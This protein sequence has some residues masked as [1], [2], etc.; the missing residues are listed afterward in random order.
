M[1]SLKKHTGFAPAINRC[2]SI[3]CFVRDL[4]FPPRPT[5]VEL[6]AAECSDVLACD[7]SGTVYLSFPLMLSSCLGDLQA[8][9]STSRHSTLAMCYVFLASVHRR[10]YDGTRFASL[11]SV[12]LDRVSYSETSAI[13]LSHF[14]CTTS[15]ASPPRR[16]RKG[17][18]S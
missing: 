4:L 13:T 3:L 10:T 8:H 17:N 5:L 2:T 12:D 7:S 1:N 6:L 9:F 16:S 18:L 11:Q 15:T 14:A